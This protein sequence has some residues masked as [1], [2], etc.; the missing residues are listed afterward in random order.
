MGISAVQRIQ[1]GWCRSG[2]GQ[3]ETSGDTHFLSSARE[4]WLRGTVKTE[5]C[6]AYKQNT[7]A[8]GPLI[9]WSEEWE[10]EPLQVRGFY[11]SFPFFPSPA[12]SYLVTVVVT[13]TQRGETFSPTTEMGVLRALGGEIPDVF[14]PNQ[15]PLCLSVLVSIPLSLGVCVGGC[16]CGC[17]YVC[18]F[19]QKKKYVHLTCYVSYRISVKKQ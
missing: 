8:E 7:C 12:P 13:V 4:A 19:W 1:T 11:S 9:F 3:I 18:S 10:R 2:S 17:V 6:T 16:G 14:S 15:T 5:R